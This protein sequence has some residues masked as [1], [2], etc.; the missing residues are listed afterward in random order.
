MWG[1]LG[2]AMLWTEAGC[3]SYC[4]WGYLMRGIGYAQASLCFWGFVDLWEILGTWAK[5]SHLCRIATE[6][7]SIQV[8][9]LGRVWRNHQGG[10]RSVSRLLETGIWCHPEPD[11]YVDKGLNKG[12]M[13]P[14]SI[15]VLNSFASP[16]L[17][18]KLHNSH[19][20]LSTWLFLIYCS[21]TG[22]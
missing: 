5:A 20:S 10:A 17:A 1:H 16:A 21:F 15:S 19:M 7:G 14:A 8:C 18:V 11:G 2:E 22:V 12:T 3:H 6:R 9:G 13:M 4:A